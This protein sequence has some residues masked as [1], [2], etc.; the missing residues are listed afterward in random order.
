MQL[1]TLELQGLTR[2]AAYSNALAE[3]AKQHDLTADQVQTL[4]VLAYLHRTGKANVSPSQINDFYTTYE[5]DALESTK[6]NVGKLAE[7]KLVVLSADQE[8][9]LSSKGVQ[10]L[11][12]LHKLHV[13]WAA[14]A[15]G[16][17]HF[18]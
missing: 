13:K 2:A 16:L 9:R 10:L 14:D 12:T 7:A 3:A 6:V 4:L 1:P 11:K 18:V 17:L 5:P 15:F 8:A